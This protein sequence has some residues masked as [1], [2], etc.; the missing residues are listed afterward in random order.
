[1]NHALQDFHGNQNTWLA[2]L[3][4]AESTPLGPHDRMTEAH[5][6]LGVR[7]DKTGVITLPF[8]DNTAQTIAAAEHLAA[9]ARSGGSRELLI[10]S[11]DRN[12]ELDLHLL[13]NGYHDGFEPWWMTR[14][15]R[16]PI[17]TPRH[18]VTA[19]TDADI[20][21]LLTSQI[22]YVMPVQIEA[23][24]RLIRESGDVRWFVAREGTAIVGQ[25]IVNLADTHAGL[26][27]VG[28]DGRHRHKGI[29][30]S[31]TNAALLAAREAG[32]LTMNLNS[33]PMGERMYLRTGFT[34]CGTGMTWNIPSTDI[35]TPVDPIR[36]DLI[37]AFGS[38]DTSAVTRMEI[39][40]SDIYEVDPQALAARFNQ[41]AML[42]HVIDL[43]LTPDIISLWKVGLR[44]EA[45]AAANDPT[46]REQTYGPRMARPLHL[47]VEMGA[48]TLVLALIRAGADINARDSE[49]H[50]TPLDW[51]HACNK[52][53]IAR[54]I[55]QAGGE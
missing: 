7:I 31:L 16:R 34:R 41:P 54:I 46:A 30:R 39:L 19:A 44:D 8:T 27:N 24:R 25:A 22:P 26:F 49:F 17:E 11:M 48:G 28:V 55:R 14:D 13:A 50:A 18:S 47:A 2:R 32:A 1:M 51:A 29:G 40:R 23:T 12:P 35:D 15:L 21:E 6:G 10:W 43:G 53:T 42:L 45:I 3:S 36:R 52:P 38:G 33:T 20:D 9:W 5:G 4:L 37:L